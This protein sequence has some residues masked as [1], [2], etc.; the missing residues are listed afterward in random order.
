M[1]WVLPSGRI[2]NVVATMVIGAYLAYIKG[3]VPVRVTLF[4]LLKYMS[5]FANG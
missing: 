5:Y 3:E 1:Y 4:L 2:M